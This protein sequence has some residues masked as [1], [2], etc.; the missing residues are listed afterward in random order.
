MPRRKIRRLTVLALVAG[1]PVAFSVWFF[2]PA[3]ALR[4]ST[5]ITY[6][7]DPLLPDG[8]PDYET[9]WNGIL[10]GDLGPNDNAMTLLAE[11]MGPDPERSR[12]PH[13]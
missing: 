5:E 6:L 11:A 13:D 8:R 2:W 1:L 4:V 9:H 7:T 10:R 3:P 12:L